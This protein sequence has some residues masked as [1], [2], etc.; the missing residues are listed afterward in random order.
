MICL[1]ITRQEYAFAEDDS[2]LV[3]SLEMMKNCSLSVAVEDQID[4]FGPFLQNSM[5]EVLLL[6]GMISCYII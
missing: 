2:S 6:D 3:T 1:V 4:R 5:I